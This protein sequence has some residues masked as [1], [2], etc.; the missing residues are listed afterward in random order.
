[1]KPIPTKTSLF[2][3]SD[4]LNKANIKKGDKVIDL[5]CGR[6]LFF[7]HNLMNLVGKNGRVYGVDIL[8][9][10][11]ESLQK[12][13]RHYGLEDIII[14]KSNIEE[15]NITLS[16]NTFQAVFFLNTLYQVTDNLAALT[17]AARVLDKDGRIV[18]VDWYPDS[19]FG[20]QIEQRVDA[21]HIKKIAQI[22]NLKLVDE[23]E[24]GRYHYGLIFTK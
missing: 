5:G 16:D 3:F 7:L 12:D 4:I 19:S 1:M 11:I 20:P 8:P 14:L 15:K 22:L 24:P 23:F 21:A 2:L 9:D 10:V 13:I 6:S 17:E 18:V